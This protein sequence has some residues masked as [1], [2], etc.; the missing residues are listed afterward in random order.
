MIMKKVV[1]CIVALTLSA[2]SANAQLGNLLNKA[3]QKAGEKAGEAAANTVMNRLGL[4]SKGNNNNNNTGKGTVGTYDGK[5]YQYS[6]DQD[7]VPT[8]Q[9]LMAQMP[10]MPAAAQLIDYKNAE[11][12]EMTLKMMTSPVTMFRTQMATLA[13]QALAVGYADMDSVR[14][15]GLTTQ[16]TGLT[17]EEIKAMENMSD[18]EQ[19]AFMM[20]YYQSGRAD[21]AR[22]KAAENTEK[23]AQMI[24][25][26]VVL[27][28][29]VNTKIDE[30]YKNAHKQMK[31][32]YEK[33][34]KQLNNAEG[35][36]YNRLMAEYYSKIVD[37]QR[38]A[39]EQAMKI[40]QN[41]QLPI[42]EK[43]EK[44]NEG[45]RKSDPTAIV[46]NYVQLFATAYFAEAEKLFEVPTYF[47]D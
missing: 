24:A 30:V 43:I 2:F 9:E 28:D 29:A 7:R 47:E 37:M 16:Y 18:E 25:D 8:I 45:I 35:K 34:E 19:E 15:A 17:P 42:A 10:A 38:N 36:A 33:Y 20:A 44:V 26:Q 23:Y 22:Q 12:N 40:R 1:F 11:A 6:N 27:F 31:P 4:N 3:A 13:V 41:E 39:V 5:D 14:L 32:I 46:P 21:I